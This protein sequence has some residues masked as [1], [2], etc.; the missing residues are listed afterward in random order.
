MNKRGLEDH[1]ERDPSG[2]IITS[3][4]KREH[5]TVK[6]KNCKWLVGVT[7]K[8][9]VKGS[10]IKTWQLY[11]GKQLHSHDMVPNPLS[12]YVHQQRM[13]EFQKAIERALAHR[14]ASLTRRAAA[15]PVTDLLLIHVKVQ[16]FR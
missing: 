7:Y 1:V 11:L 10:D 15:L 8:P 13:P 6:Q 14:Q 9:T 5:T 2:E 4:R 12:Y 16:S 3:Q